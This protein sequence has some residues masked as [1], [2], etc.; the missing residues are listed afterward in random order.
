MEAIH[1]FVKKI[2]IKNKSFPWIMEKQSIDYLMVLIFP[3][4]PLGHFI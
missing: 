2:I 3:I 4:K 1:A